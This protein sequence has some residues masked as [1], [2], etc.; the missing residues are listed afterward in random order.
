[1][2]NRIWIDFK[3]N[4]DLQTNEMHGLICLAS[5]MTM[6]HSITLTGWRGVIEYAETE[7]QTGFNT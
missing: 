7:T 5:N 4:W 1:M 2:L 3:N 6:G